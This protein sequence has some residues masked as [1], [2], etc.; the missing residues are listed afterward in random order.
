MIFSSRIFWKMYGGFL[1]FFLIPIIFAGVSIVGKMEH[2]FIEQLKESLVSEAILLQIIAEESISGNSHSAIQ[3]RL[4][5]IPLEK[6]ARLTVIL[7]NGEVLGDTEKDPVEMDNHSNRPEILTARSHGRGF[8]TRYSDTLNTNMMYLALLVKNNNGFNGYV[9]TSVSL[10]SVEEKLG[11]I[12][13]IVLFSAVSAFIAALILGLFFARHFALP[14]SNMTSV[15]QSMSQGDY[16]RRLSVNRLDEFGKLA[17][18]YNVMAESLKIRIGTI[19][20]E[21][22]K[23]QTILT[24]MIEGVIALDMSE[25]IVHINAAAGRILE[26]SPPEC[27]GKSIWKIASFMELKEL[28]ANVFNEKAGLKTKLKLARQFKDTV[29]EMQISPIYDITHAP[30]GSVIVMHDVSE[31]HNLEKIRRDFVAN[32]SHELKTPITAIRGLIETIIDDEE[33]TIDNRKNFME[34]AKEQTKRLTSLV[35]DILALARL[36]SESFVMEKSRVNI[37]RIILDAV[38]S[39]SPVSEEREIEIA[40]ELPDTSVEING[41][42]NAITSAISNLLDNALKY[43][44]PKG[45]IVVRLKTDGLFGVVEIQDNGVGIEQKHHHRIFERFYRV[46]KAR[47]RE[48]GGTG[49]GLA[50]VK[51]VAQSHGG[52]VDLESVPGKG[53]IF[54]ITLPLATTLA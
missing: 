32:I 17:K 4:K 23:L 11:G 38:K 14:L 28:L 18:A 41:D 47:S 35:D 9:R 20:S 24:G 5:Q 37:N 29:I 15:A 51:H 27:L 8:S 25:N 52:K 49:L 54:R 31:L 53:S 22:N 10:S 46:D 42:E 7:E 21:R 45:K 36:E 1:V 33:I 34:R 48:L 6:G 26:V 43:T 50:I 19:D 13:N 30:A 3:E 39:L 16:D 44:P 2:D 40:T 12:R